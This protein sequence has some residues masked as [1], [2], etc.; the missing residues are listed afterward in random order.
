MKKYLSAGFIFLFPIAITIWI[1][2]YLFDLFTT[3]FYQIAE[4]ALLALEKRWDLAPL[5]HET[6][7]IFLSR[8]VALIATL[9]LILILGFLGRKYFFKTLLSLANALMLRIP[10]IGTIYR[11]TKDITKVVLSADEKTFKKTILF[12]FPTSQTHTLGFITSDEIPEKLKKAAENAEL[13][14][15]VPT[16]PHPIS[17]YVLLTPKKGIHEVDISVEDTF[18]FLVSCGIIYPATSVKT[19][20]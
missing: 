1:V 4:G 14:V 17:G 8:L 9:V 11:L 2:L 3:P 20:A 7:V 5:H 16:A 19:D 15:F 10:V 18:K 12:P 6:F 13:I